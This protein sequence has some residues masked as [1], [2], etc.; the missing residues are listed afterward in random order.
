MKINQKN[1]KNQKQFLGI[2]RVIIVS[3]NTRYFKKY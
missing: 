2:H 3:L 1:Q